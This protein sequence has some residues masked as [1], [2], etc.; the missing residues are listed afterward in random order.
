M[1][2]DFAIGNPPYQTS[3]ETYNRQEPIYTH[4]YDATEKVADKSLLI[5]PARFLFNG[6]LTSKE[7]NKKMLS[8]EHLKVE[9]YNERAADVF[10]TAQIKGGIAVV[11]RDSKQKFGAIGEFIP[12]ESLRKIASHFTNDKS[13]NL[14]SIMF[15]GRSDL[16]FN[17]LFVKENPESIY[18]RIKAIQKKHPEV[19]ELAPN[20]EYELKS[21][22]LE[23]LGFLFESQMPAKGNGYYKI[24]G[25]ENGKRVFKW[26]EKRYMEPRYPK[27]N[28]I[29]KYKVIF[30][31]ATGNG[32]L[33]E[34]LST[35][36]IL[37]PMESATPTFISIGKFD[38]KIEAEAALK[39]I[40]TKLVRALLGI[41]KKTQHTA[42]ANWAYVPLQ[43]FTSASD[44]DWTKSI[45][46]IDLQ[47]YKKYGLTQEEIDFIE[48]NVKEME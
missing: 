18:A 29:D 9:Y 17:E 34:T 36:T 35:P 24:L 38:T 32:L 37:E 7:W 5:T 16:K 23:I 8:D 41:L 10:P 2:F 39:Y 31:E 45:H 4:F 15:G 3:I 1:K 30:P 21:S 47:L 13:K 20:E 48:S 33:G 42:P 12:N 40:K 25:L 44:I 19:N 22:T 43:D 14:P 11:Y 28:N 46:E 26:I 27:K 6:G